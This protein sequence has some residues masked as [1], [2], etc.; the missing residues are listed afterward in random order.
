MTEVKRILLSKLH[1]IE[2][3]VLLG[4]IIEIFERH[5]LQ[6]LH[7]QNIYVLLLEQQAIAKKLKIPYGKHAL[8]D[9]LAQLH[10][11]RLKYATL[12]NTHV[13][14]L[15]EFEEET[16]QQ[17]TIEMQKLTRKYLT[18]LG[19]KSCVNVTNQIDMFFSAL[20]NSPLEEVFAELGLNHYLQELQKA[21]K[22]YD[23]L[24]KKRK[25]DIENRPLTGDP[26]VR[27]HTL[28]IIRVVLYSINSNQSV[29]KDIDYSPLID[30]LNV[31]LTNYSKKIK[32]RI[33][34][35]KRR[36]RKKAEAAKNGSNKEQTVQGN[37]DKAKEQPDKSDNETRA[38]QKNKGSNSDDDIY[39]RG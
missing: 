37:D 19:R 16:T 23:T 6:A 9:K 11:K 17:Q 24:C 30:N 13:K 25:S 28:K 12:I 39:K 7:L 33:A 38:N 5:D 35:N 15:V 31:L 20:T 8:T 32:N 10:N 26:E 2:I 3:P 22:N 4:N 14:L 27:E 18:Y 34:T 1:N 29:Y 36:A 21:N